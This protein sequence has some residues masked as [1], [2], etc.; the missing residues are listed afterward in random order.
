M[1]AAAADLLLRLSVDPL[2]TARPFAFAQHELLDLSCARLGLI[3]ESNAARRFE[4]RNLLAAESLPCLSS[5]PA[6]F[7][8]W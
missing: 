7:S 4:V 3:A 8:T 1:P 2:L 6:P 5:R